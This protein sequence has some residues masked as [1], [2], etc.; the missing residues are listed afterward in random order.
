MRQFIN[1]EANTLSIELVHSGIGWIGFGFGAQMIDSNAVIGLPE[2]AINGA[3]TNPALYNLGGFDPSAILPLDDQTNLVDAKIE[4]DDVLTK[5]TFTI[6]INQEGAPTVVDGEATDIIWA[7]GVDNTFAYHQ[8]NRSPTTAV[9]TKC[10]DLFP[11]VRVSVPEYYLLYDIPLVFEKPSRKVADQLIMVTE[12]FWDQF[13]TEFYSDGVIQYRGIQQLSEEILFEDLSGGVDGTPY[14]L[15]IFKTTLLYLGSVEPPGPDDTLEV[16]RNADFMGYIMNYVRS[17][18]EFALTS[19]V[20]LERSTFI[21]VHVKDYFLAYAVPL[22]FENPSEEVVE[23][24]VI[25]TEEFWHDYLTEFYADQFRYSGHYLVY[26]EV[27]F[28]AGIPESKFNYL[29][30]FE[31]TLLYEMGPG[32]PPGPEQTFGIMQNADLFDY[33]WGLVRTITEFSST[34][35]VVLLVQG[36]LTA[37]PSSPPA[38]EGFDIDLDLTDVLPQYRG[39]LTLAKMR[40]E[41]IITEDAPDHTVTDLNIGQSRCNSLPAV[42]DDLFICASVSFVD[43][44]GAVLATAAPEFSR[45]TSPF[46]AGGFINFDTDDV[47]RLILE[48]I[49]DGVVVSPFKPVFCFTSLVTKQCCSQSIQQVHEMAHV[50]RP[51]FVGS[52][53]VA[54]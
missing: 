12:Q 48:G 9:F 18:P 32:E 7:H 29:I 27:L 44:P 4:Q 52:F 10:V 22:L 42:I 35:D 25:F 47:D 45:S 53:C 37:S 2:G 46:P 20:C 13:F 38:N 19:E 16:M 11:L 36:F 41:Q 23:Q 43:G 39:A 49:F 8:S 33:N 50:V 24:L 17:I 51:S 21:R 34:T 3:P 30:R 15:V 26:D 31:T 28:E 6:K 40:W 5:M 54:L 14:Y 1:E